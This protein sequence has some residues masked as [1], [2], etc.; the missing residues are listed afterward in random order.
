VTP[1]QKKIWTILK[2]NRGRFVRSEELRRS[3]GREIS[4]NQL[5]VQIS[6][7]RK[8]VAGRRLR[9]ISQ[10]G[11]RSRGYCLTEEKNERSTG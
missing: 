11:P 4:I 9:I 1:T 8:E 2:A 10:P 3:V 7:L 6:V 5:R